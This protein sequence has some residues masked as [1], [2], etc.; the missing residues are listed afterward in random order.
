[1]GGRGA[2]NQA[3]LVLTIPQPSRLWQF[4]GPFFL[5]LSS[6]FSW[7][8]PGVRLVSF[9]FVRWVKFPR[10]RNRKQAS[11]SPSRS[12]FRSIL[13]PR[14]RYVQIYHMFLC[15]LKFPR[16]RNSNIGWLGYPFHNLVCWEYLWYCRIRL[17][18]RECVGYVEVA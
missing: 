7:R 4:F 17:K 8:P 1:M 14:V 9:R 13:L 12:R 10:Y 18:Q 2:E 11:I 3:Y 15:E 6:P 5:F 16:R